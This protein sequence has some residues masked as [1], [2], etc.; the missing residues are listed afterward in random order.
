MMQ[1][2]KERRREEGRKSEVVEGRADKVDVDF[3]DKKVDQ[4]KQLLT[5]L[6][7]L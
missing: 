5:L 1:S 3:Q 4:T 2:P 7:L 6:Y